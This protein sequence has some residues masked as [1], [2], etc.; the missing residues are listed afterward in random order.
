MEKLIFEAY[1]SE[2]AGF[3]AAPAL[4]EYLCKAFNLPI[5]SLNDKYEEII[6]RINSNR[7]YRTNQEFG[8]LIYSEYMRLLE[9]LEDSANA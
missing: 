9:E 5:G 8:E 7:T 6:R 2:Q 1:A 4:E 3:S